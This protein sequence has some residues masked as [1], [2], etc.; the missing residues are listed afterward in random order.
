MNV[1][2]NG[3][4]VNA[5]RG[6]PVSTLVWGARTMDGNSQDWR[7]VSVRRTMTFLEQSIKSSAMFL[8]FSNNSTTWSTLRQQLVTLNQWVVDS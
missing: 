4:A 3:K 2:L 7:Y 6:L 1:P 8:F 5:I